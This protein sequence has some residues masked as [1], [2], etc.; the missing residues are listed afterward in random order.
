MAGEE[1]RKF[2][3]HPEVAS[4]LLSKKV[5]AINSKGLYDFDNKVTENAVRHKLGRV[6]RRLSYVE[7]ESA[8]AVARSTKL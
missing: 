8:S 1:Y 4:R 2:C 3:G 5:F 6:R 7:Y